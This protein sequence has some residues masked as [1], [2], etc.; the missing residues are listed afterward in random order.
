MRPNHVRVPLRPEL[1]L[2]STSN[3]ASTL[4]I[5]FFLPSEPFSA[6]IA[7]WLLPLSSH[8]HL[9][10]APRLARYAH[11]SPNDLAPGLPLCS[12]FWIYVYADSGPICNSSPMLWLV[13][14]PF[15]DPASSVF[16]MNCHPPRIT[17]QASA[18]MLSPIPNYR[19][20]DPDRG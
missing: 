12:V 16:P 3:S 15:L 7:A 10:T 14:N 13:P 4:N 19:C 5:H 8:P 20:A 6:Q 17:R 1:D 11:L 9:S 2:L 18:L